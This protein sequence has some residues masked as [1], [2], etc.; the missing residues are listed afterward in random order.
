[1]KE[2][3]LLTG[4]SGMLGKKFYEVAC[5]DFEIHRQYRNKKSLSGNEY[6]VDLS[7][8]EE[9]E[10]LFQS[11]PNVKHVIHFSAQATVWKSLKYPTE[12]AIANVLSL[13][14]LAS[15]FGKVQ[16]GGKFIHLSSEAVYGDEIS[17]NE[18][19]VK[20]PKSP[21]GLS[22]YSSELYLR[23]FG[24]TSKFK[25]AIVRPSFVIGND[26]KRNP[27]FDILSKV[28]DGNI[29]LRQSKQSKFNFVLDRHV[30]ERIVEI[31]RK[32]DVRTDYNVINRDNMNLA[33]VLDF[34]NRRGLDLNI[35]E[36][37]QDIQRRTL[38]SIESDNFVSTKQDV[39]DFCDQYLICN[40]S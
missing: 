35:V 17:P 8:P 40:N 4:A 1:M 13:I 36:L 21:Y 37:H 18:G 28:P 30:C 20:S 23:Y 22:K 29:E 34:L 12:D 11:I 2:V 31:L 25:F 5:D 19:S 26:M 38:S 15:T 10:R 32:T 27:L 14:N 24:E 6:N 16:S 39:L 33:E 3:I 9:V 7:S